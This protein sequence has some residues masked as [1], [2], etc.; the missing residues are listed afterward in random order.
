MKRI[1]IFDGTRM[2][3]NPKSIN[4]TMFNDTLFIEDE[5]EEKE[6][7]KDMYFIIKVKKMIE[8]NLECI[9]KMLDNKEETIKSSYNHEFALKINNKTYIINRNICNEE[10]QKLFDDFKMKLYEI[11]DI[12]R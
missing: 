4:I 8:D 3:N 1:F 12:K 2:P 11:L 9:E 10:G 7:Y 5:K 6:N